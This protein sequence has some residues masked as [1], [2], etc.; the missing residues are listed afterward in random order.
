MDI[1]RPVVD[2]C[3]AIRQVKA[4]TILAKTPI[5]AVSSFAM[6]GDEEK[7]RGA[8]AAGC[9][10]YVTNNFC[11]PSVACSARKDRGPSRPLMVRFLPFAMAKRASEMG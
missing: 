9:D 10:H 4:D 5:I 3:E 11:A 2:G 8:R 1:Q 7:A 6:K